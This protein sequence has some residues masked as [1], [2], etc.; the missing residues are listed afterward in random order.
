MSTLRRINLKDEDVVMDERG[1]KDP[2]Y[3]CLP[4]FRGRPGAT[5]RSPKKGYP[6]HLV[7]Q[8]RV[9]GLFDSWAEAQA[10][11]VGYPGNANRGF[12]SVE[13]A[14]D[15]WQGMCTL[16]VHPH[17]VDPAFLDHKSE[18]ERDPLPQLEGKPV[19]SRAETVAQKLSVQMKNKLNPTNQVIALSSS[20]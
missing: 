2:R 15:A 8:G 4:P 13:D 6:L 7:F 19:A 1:V 16:G 18:D 17:P 20:D 14:T 9:V 11:L 5:T 12:Y 10:S 3:Y